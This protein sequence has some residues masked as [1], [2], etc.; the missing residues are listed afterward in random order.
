MLIKRSNKIAI[1]YKDKSYTYNETVHNIN[2]LAKLYTK[3]AGKVAVFAENRPEWAF[4]FYSAW[5]NDCIAI[6]I[7]YMS[8][9]DEVNY[10]LNDSNP[11]I[12]FCS[13][14]T[15]KLLDQLLPNLNYSP[16]FISFDDIKIDEIEAD[17]SELEI[18]DVMKT[19]LIIYTSGT[20]SYPKGV[21]L[22]F[23]NLIANAEA[24]VD[25]KIYTEKTRV[26]VL[27]PLH[28]ALPLMGTLIIPFTVQGTIAFSPSLNAEDLIATLK[29][30]KITMLIGVPRFYSLLRRKIKE[31]INQKAIT[32]GIFAL[33]EKI[34]SMSFS[35]KIFKKVHD[36]FGGHLNILVCGG[37]ALDYEVE[38]DFRTLGFE[39]LVGYGMTECAPMISFPRMGKAKFG[40]SG[41]SLSCNEIRVVDNEIITRGR[42]IMQGYYNKPE[43]TAE[44]IKDGWLYTGDLGHLDEEGHV[45]I[46]GRKKELIILSNG[47]NISP[48]EIEE[49]IAGVSDVVLENAVFMKG[50]SLQ[51]IIYPDPHKVEKLNVPDLNEWVKWN[52]ID[53]YNQSAAHYKKITR[54]FI[55]NSELPRTRLGKIKRYELDNFLN[56]PDIKKAKVEEPKFAEYIAIRDYL[57]ELKS[58]DVFPHDHLEIDLGL[59]SLDKVSFQLFIKNSYGLDLSTE[60]LTKFEN[61]IVLSEY[62]RDNKVKSESES[63]DWSSIFKQRMD[64]TL[65]KSWFTHQILKSFS[66]LLLKLYF[67]V[68]GEGVENIPDGP[69]IIAPNHQS[70][71]DGLFV[72]M[73]MKT[74]QLKQT[75]YYAKEKHVNNQV[76]KFIAA[77]HNVI[78]M[79]LNNDLM[80]SLQKLAE[81]LK[82]G[83]KIMIFPEGTRTKDG[84][85]G[86]FKRAFVILARELNVPIVPVAISGAYD[87]LPTGSK[88]PK[89]WK[90]IKVQFMKPIYPEGH[91]YDSLKDSVYETLKK[92]VKK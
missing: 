17:D 5:K 37:A 13:S 87:A 49:K 89:P 85:L 62:M 10:I 23:D 81:V 21:M 44:M 24:V 82:R 65:P 52:I 60:Q 7:D 2:R 69:V 40:A 8:T 4:A 30:H 54:F 79:D 78:V 51:I 41:Q 71:I 6:T 47:K 74:K 76:V 33:A 16:T 3:E 83:K 77:K 64:L 12:V 15:K 39:I 61:L 14:E 58:Q 18:K 56:V 84:D 25:A 11:S 72:S 43:E 48:V 32:K 20:T 34:D 26:I 31:K 46:T 38:R 91:T 22:S 42:N 53:K 28:H 35:R 86:N 1:H 55:V 45:F 19:A 80:L 50:D 9:A 90:K 27:L 75:Y 29:Q 36:G 68:K 66:K 70:F 67:R 57:K 88:F 92:A 73:F 59:D 63:V